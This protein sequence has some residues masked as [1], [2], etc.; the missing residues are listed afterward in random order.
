[1]YRVAN[2]S[3][4]YSTRYYV[5]RADFSF[6]C[7]LLIVPD[8]Y[9]I[10]FSDFTDLTNFVNSLFST[11]LSKYILKTSQYPNPDPQRTLKVDVHIFTFLF[12]AKM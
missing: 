7:S 11:L 10:S 1:M 6:F 5:S 8:P 9:S 4:V 12:F 3:C 2:P